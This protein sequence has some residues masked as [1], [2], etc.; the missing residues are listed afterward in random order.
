MAFQQKV[1]G[2]SLF[3]VQNERSGNVP[4]GQFWFLESALSH[5]W[6]R[7]DVNKRA[8]DSLQTL[9]TLQIMCRSVFL[10]VSHSQENIFADDEGS[11]VCYRLKTDFADDKIVC[12]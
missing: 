10:S 9:Q 12:S 5:A 3:D 4:V 6:F 11:S 7:I 1:F 2:K 8:K